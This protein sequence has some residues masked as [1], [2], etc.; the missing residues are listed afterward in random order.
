MSPCVR[1]CVVRLQQHVA[2]QVSGGSGRG[3]PDI[4]SLL[5]PMDQCA[6]VADALINRLNTDQ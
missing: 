5:P 2:E 3:L 6:D 1:Y 4:H